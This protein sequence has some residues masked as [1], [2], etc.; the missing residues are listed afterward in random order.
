[1]G[2]EAHMRRKRPG[3]T[4]QQLL[5]FIKFDSASLYAALVAP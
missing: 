5:G 1:M 3:V 2:D 4:R